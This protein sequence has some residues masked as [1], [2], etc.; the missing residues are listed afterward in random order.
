M[1]VAFMPPQGQHRCEPKNLGDLIGQPGSVG[2]ATAAHF[3]A[4]RSG[5]E[6]ARLKV[7]VRMLLKTEEASALISTGSAVAS[8]VNVVKSAFYTMSSKAAQPM[9]IIASVQRKDLS[10]AYCRT[11]PALNRSVK[12]RWMKIVPDSIGAVAPADSAGGVSDTVG[13]VMAT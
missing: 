11:L 5:R 2:T 9:K 10:K 1:R 3:H 13:R 6:K 8:I 4:A 7:P 12:F